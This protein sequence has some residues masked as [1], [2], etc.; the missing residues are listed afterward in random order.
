MSAGVDSVAVTGREVI[1][2]TPM[3][4]LGHD[5][6]LKEHKVLYNTGSRT[7]AEGLATFQNVDIPVSQI[8]HTVCTRIP[9]L[10]PVE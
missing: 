4:S 1:G 5:G 7:P 3:T 10:A 9:I 6:V 8:A 2:R